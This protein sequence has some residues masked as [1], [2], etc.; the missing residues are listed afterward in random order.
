MAYEAPVLAAIPHNRSA[1]SAENGHAPI[2]YGT[3]EAFRTLRSNLQLAHLDNEMTTLLVTSALPEEG[4]S[5]VVKHLAMAYR[6]AGTRVAVVELDLRRP[7]LAK[8][9]GLR[10]QPGLTEAL[11]SGDGIASAMQTVGVEVPA[12]VAEHSDVD[13]EVVQTNGALGMAESGGALAVLTSG[14]IPANPSSILAT[15]RIRSV[16]KELAEDF[17]VVL[18]D[19]APVLA[20]GDT[21]TLLSEVDAVVLVSRMGSSTRDAAKSLVETIHR[22][23]HV[24]VLGVAVNDVPESQTSY[25]AT[26]YDGVPG[27]AIPR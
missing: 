8:Q 9:F 12:A 20:V 5:T 4:K 17:D 21:L 6:E 18:I 25:P 7:T 3:Q 14:A 2:P 23:P 11:V 22:A 13:P 1:N 16:L 10:R 19:T 24:R 15:Q 26:R 27:A